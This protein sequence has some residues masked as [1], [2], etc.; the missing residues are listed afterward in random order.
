[1]RAKYQIDT[2]NTII[3]KPRT[4]KPKQYVENPKNLKGRQK[5]M[6]NEERP[7]ARFFFNISQMF[8]FIRLIF[9]NI[10]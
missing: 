4:K 1:M 9:G 8:D 10:S 2:T 3:G 7:K 5:M 6:K